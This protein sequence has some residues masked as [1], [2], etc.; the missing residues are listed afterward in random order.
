[1]A[2]TFDK[3]S[4][5]AIHIKI[6]TFCIAYSIGVALRLYVPLLYS[7]EI[8]P[9]IFLWLYFYACLYT[10]IFMAMQSLASKIP[11]I[12]VPYML[13]V[14][15]CEGI[16]FAAAFSGF[17]HLHWY[18]YPIGAAA[19]S[20]SGALFAFSLYKCD[21]AYQSLSNLL[22]NTLFGV[23]CGMIAA[24]IITPILYQ[25]FA[26]KT[27]GFSAFQCFV[28]SFFAFIPVYIVSSIF[29]RRHVAS[30]QTRFDSERQ[31]V[32]RDQELYAEKCARSAADK[33]AR[34]KAEKERARKERERQEREKNKRSS[35]SSTGSSGK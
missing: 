4:A 3:K 9:G 13:L 14:G 35:S 34:A 23:S 15:C 27:V 22:C 24:W 21:K 33:E 19:G 16:S 1:M 20:I 17:A 26:T 10:L 30:A 8:D 12:I 25:D 28:I 2:N 18:I 29:I 32:M 11:G 7:K 5:F 31:Q 6:G